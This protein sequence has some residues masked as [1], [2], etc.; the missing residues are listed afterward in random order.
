MNKQKIEKLWREIL[1]EIGENPDRP[2]LVETPKRIAKMYEEIFYGYD[3]NK[4]PKITLFG[5]NEDQII[6]DDIII[7]SGCFNSYCEHH[8]ALFSGHYYL[9]YIPGKQIVG[10]SKIARIVDFF[11]ARLQIQERLGHQIVDYIDSILQPQG[12]I[13]LLK[14]THSCKTIR[15][16]KKQGVMKTIVA[17]GIFRSDPLLEQKFL[18]LIK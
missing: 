14:A 6:Y 2:G 10:L 15:G 17:T 3:K 12:I 18:T 1:I 5:N 7:D 11:S 13:L 4:L 9:G 8:Q 16:V